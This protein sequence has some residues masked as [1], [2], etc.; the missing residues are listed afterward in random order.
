MKYSRKN[1]NL[2]ESEISEEE[3]NL[4]ESEIEDDEDQEIDD[5]DSEAEIY[6]SDEEEEPKYQENDVEDD[7]IPSNEEIN[8][9]TNILNGIRSSV[10]DANKKINSV[11]TNFSQPDK[12]EIKY[13]ISYLDSKNNMMLIYI[14]NYILYFLKKINGD[15]IDKSP[16]LK[17]LIYLK[18]YLE[19]SKIIDL[20]LKTQIDKLIKLGEKNLDDK[21]NNNSSY[22]ENNLRPRILE[23]EEENEEN[24]NQEEEKL[25]RKSKYKVQ[26]NFQEFFETSNENKKRHKKIEKMKA[27]V[28]NS[29]VYKEIRDQFNENPTEINNYDTEYSK[30]M[31]EIEDYED[32]HFT[33][34]KVPKGELK[35][36]KKLDRKE[37]DFS[38]VGREFKNL[39]AILNQDDKDQYEDEM[40]FLNKKT[41]VNKIYNN[42]KNQNQ[43]E[44]RRGTVNKRGSFSNRRD[45]FK[46]D[47]KISLF[48]KKK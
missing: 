5:N 7:Y 28:K 33:R 37:N 45:P 9:F 30:F 42:G 1:N 17:Q 4:N 46:H 29:E 11:L 15:S 10:D 24:E 2:K 12:A 8:E 35:K 43:F 34:I 32:D 6:K 16:I 44:G 39:D 40:K 41:A 36:L 21:T 20:K 26:K 25:D 13:G 19:R 38:D 23:N 27:K 31:K 22:D 48:R 3:S 14:S 47:K 18:T